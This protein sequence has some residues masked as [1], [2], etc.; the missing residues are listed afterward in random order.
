MTS[1]PSASQVVRA[2]PQPNIYTALLMVAVVVLL[3]TLGVVLFTLLSP[4][5][6]GYGLEF[7]DLLKPLS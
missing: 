1:V 4:M 6:K 3:V 2:K 7:G 5:P